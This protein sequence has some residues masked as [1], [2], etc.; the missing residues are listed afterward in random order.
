MGVGTGVVGYGL[1]QLYKAYRAEFEAHLKREQIS[2]KVES[3]I[4]NGGRFGLAAR[5][6]VFGLVGL[7]FIMVSWRFDPNEATGLGG[8]LRE[9]LRQPLS[10]W[11]LL[12]VALRLI[13]YGLLML[14]MARHGRI[15]SGR[16]F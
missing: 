7:L 13:A 10:S 16:A 6:I 1:H 12:I 15:A 8:A 9:L 5:G 2:E 3:V 14:A 4:A 11:I